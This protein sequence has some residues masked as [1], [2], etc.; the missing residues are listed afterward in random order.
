MLN[1]HNTLIFKEAIINNTSAR[2]ILDYNV[3]VHDQ[4]DDLKKR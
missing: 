3:V 1:E 4:E 2:V